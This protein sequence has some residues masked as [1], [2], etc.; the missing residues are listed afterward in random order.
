LSKKDGHFLDAVTSVDSGTLEND[1]ESQHSFQSFRAKH[2]P[3]ELSR[4]D[5]WEYHFDDRKHACCLKFARGPILPS[6]PAVSDPR[7][8]W[9][10]QSS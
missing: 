8:K 6:S 10:S 7:G 3:I 5:I 2:D 9:N 1:A 4:L